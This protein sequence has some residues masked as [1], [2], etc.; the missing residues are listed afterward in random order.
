[1]MTESGMCGQNYS[2]RI[3]KINTDIRIKIKFNE[4]KQ[5]L[6]IQTSFRIYF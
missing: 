1:M 3:K 2:Y 4:D 5:N 6:Q